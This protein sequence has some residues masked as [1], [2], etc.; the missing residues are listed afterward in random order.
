MSNW[1]NIDDGYSDPDIIAAQY[2]AGGTAYFEVELT[3]AE[4]NDRIVAN[5]GGNAGSPNLI[6]ALGIAIKER[7]PI[8]VIIPD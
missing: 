5:S 4:F 1:R 6:A 3:L 2:K 8:E 7:D